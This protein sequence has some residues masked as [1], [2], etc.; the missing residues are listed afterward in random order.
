MVSETLHH[1]DDG[2][3]TPPA[4]PAV[5]YGYAGFWK[6]AAAALIDG[7][8]TNVLGGLFM[9]FAVGL[10][11]GAAPQT[12][13][14]AGLVVAAVGVVMHWLYFALFESSSKQATPGKMAVGIKVTDADDNRISFGRASGRH[15]CKILS[16]LFLLAGYVMAAFTQK[17]QGLHDILS[18]CLVVNKSEPKKSQTVLIGVIAVA[19]L[20]PAIGAIGILSAALFPAIGN[21]MLQANMTAMSTR[22]KDI[23]VAI[24][25][26]N[27][28]RE[29][30][31]L[32]T[33]WPRSGQK[34]EEGDDISKMRFENSSD[35]FS[36][37][38]DSGK[39]GTRDWTPYVFGFDYSKCAGA[40]V[41]AKEEPGRLTA[42]N[43]AWIV[44]A[45]VTDDMPDWLPLFI[46]RNVDPASFIPEAG[47]L[48]EQYIR[49]SG[50]HI[51]PFGNKGFVMIRKGGA[52]VRMRLGRHSNLATV[53]Q[54]TDVQEI[55]A[56]LE[57]IEY[58]A[59]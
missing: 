46:T 15:F 59:P 12:G 32:G 4:F 5:A 36:V 45:N 49:P 35:Y 54:G 8:I 51:T 29:S 21:A 39:L 40:G 27:M 2:Q 57:K 22:A 7:I 47:D 44:A 18:G 48:R 30:L 10:I 24:V 11:Y 37:L 1:A 9:G 58:L 23:Y 25:S 38:C 33:V 28:E 14:S 19:G 52:V 34:M 17:K 55:R 50:K 6:R 31:G 16:C 13:K 26:A 3:Q 56:A 41:P 42:A 43:N 20:F 53:Y